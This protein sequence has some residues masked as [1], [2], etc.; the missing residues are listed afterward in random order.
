MN[1][2]YHTGFTNIS[3]GQIMRWTHIGRLQPNVTLVIDTIIDYPRYWLT[4]LKMKPTDKKIS[5]PPRIAARKHSNV[6]H[7]SQTFLVFLLTD[8]SYCFQ[9]S[10][11]IRQHILT[12]KH[13]FLY[14]QDLAWERQGSQTNQCQTE[15]MLIFLNQFQLMETSRFS[16]HQP[17]RKMG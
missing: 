17:S 14:P 9:V 16:F 4:C 3:L 1:L 12:R 11:N 13:L 15:T 7:V 5:R 2:E 8:G 10:C 6:Q